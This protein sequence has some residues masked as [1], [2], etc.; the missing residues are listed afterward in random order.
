MNSKDLDTQYCKYKPSSFIFSSYISN[1]TR[2]FQIY[3]QVLMYYEKE[4]EPGSLGDRF[5]AHPTKTL[6]LILTQ[7][8]K[9]H[10][11]GNGTKQRGKTN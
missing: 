9:T 7:Y 3:H 6:V 4:K 2:T 11:T 10:D 8:A 5:H 1:K